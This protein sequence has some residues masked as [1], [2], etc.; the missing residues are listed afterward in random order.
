M[1][2]HAESG[3]DIAKDLGVLIQA[4]WLQQQLG[5]N[6]ESYANMQKAIDILSDL[7]ASLSLFEYIRYLE[8]Q[9][10][11][12]LPSTAVCGGDSAQL[13]RTGQR[14]KGSGFVFEVLTVALC[15]SSDGVATHIIYSD[16]RN[17]QS[18][19]SIEMYG[20]LEV[21][22]KLD[23]EMI[24]SGQENA[25]QLLR[26]KESWRILKWLRKIFRR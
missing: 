3:K 26:K 13:I 1:N 8:R 24:D 2:E 23:M 7:Y 21:I 15:P 17:K 11:R 5:N 6:K 4:A 25:V 9:N 19:F 16:S 12:V 10:G 18:A 22:M 14:W 20:F